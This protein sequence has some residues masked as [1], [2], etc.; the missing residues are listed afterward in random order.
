MITSCSL[1]VEVSGGMVHSV[2]HPAPSDGERSL[3]SPATERLDQPYRNHTQASLSAAL[4]QSGESVAPRSWVWIHPAA[5]P[6]EE[7]PNE[8]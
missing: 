2:P 7:V 1:R 3:A 4:R 8:A 6:T 5:I